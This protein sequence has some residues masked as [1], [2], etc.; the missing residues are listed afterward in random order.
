MREQ[1]R[2]WRRDPRPGALVIVFGVAAV[3]FFALVAALLLYRPFLAVDERFSAAVRG[4]DAP[5]VETVLSA[6]THLG[7]FWV[8]TALTLVTCG[9]LW[10][11]QRRAEALLL[12]VTVGVGA[13]LGNLVREV[14]ER[15]RPG[16]ELAR[17]PLPE[18]YSLPS[19]HALATFLFF[20]IVAFVGLME[21]RRLPGRVVILA[22]C[23]AAAGLVALSRVY[24]GVHYLGDVIASWILGSAWLTFMVGVYFALTNGEEPG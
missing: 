19:G 15:A 18:T 1:P 4:I 3:A 11:R 23:I 13:L 8:A 10:W 9:V 5:L 16:L 14:V 2:L 20:G 22:L 24:L 7:D 12:L 17:I 6:G 21:A